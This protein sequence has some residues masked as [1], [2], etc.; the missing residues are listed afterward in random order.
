MNWENWV[1][2]HLE[3]EL[4]FEQEQAYQNFVKANPQVE[5]EIDLYRKAFF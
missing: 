2:A 1:I 5:T 3:G 4:T